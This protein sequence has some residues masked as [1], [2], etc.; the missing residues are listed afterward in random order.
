MKSLFFCLLLTL[1]S[2]PAVAETE[3]IPL[4]HRSVDEVLPVIRPLLDQDGVASG[5][6]NQLILRTSPRNLAEIRKV[7]ESIDRAPRRLRI[8]VLQ[9]VDR[10][11]MSRLIEASGSVGVGGHARVTVAPADGGG[12]T[13]EAAQGEDRLHVRA[14]STRSLQGDHKGQQ[15][16]VLEGNRAFIQAGAAAPIPQ[17]RI[18]QSPSGTRVID[19]TGYR[20]VTSG[21]YVLPRVS[22]DRVTLEIST[23]NDSLSSGQRGYPAPDIQQAA[24]TLSGKLG[25]WLVVG[26]IAQRQESSGG[27]IA[28]RSSSSVSEQRNV[29][30]K[31]EEVE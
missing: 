15:V 22:G 25:E 6:N 5:M 23:R 31:V 8:T 10:A 28:S 9:N 24:T 26:D 17:R 3:V 7:L 29:L 16:Q 2:P 19:A 27:T 14:E 18:V 1:P 30:L 20:D 4:R 21:F 11:T 12:L 13:V